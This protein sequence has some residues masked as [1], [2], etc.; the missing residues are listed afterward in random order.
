M[1]LKSLELAVEWPSDITIFHLRHY[2]IT[3]LQLVGDPLR[4]AIT[5]S[6]PSAKSKIFRELTIEA[7][8]II[9]LKIDVKADA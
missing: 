6:K 7:I 1:K 2:L 4:W 5:S 9:P 8:V 3:Q